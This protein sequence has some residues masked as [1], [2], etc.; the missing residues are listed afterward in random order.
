MNLYQ[1][2]LINYGHITMMHEYAAQKGVEL[3]ISKNGV[4]HEVRKICPHCDILCNYNGSNKTGN[5]LSRSIGAFFKK[6]QQCCSNC[7]RTYQIDNEFID[8]II[9]ESNQFIMSVALSLREKSM[10]YADIS[11]HFCETLHISIC[12]ETLRDICEKKLSEY[13]DLDIEFEVEDDFYGYDE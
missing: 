4:I 12:V 2:T 13:D 11:K 9:L 8:A 5:I 7:G 1:P 6:G 10:S 3:I